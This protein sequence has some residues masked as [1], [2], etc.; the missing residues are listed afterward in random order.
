AAR[1]EPG[2]VG[3]RSAW[4]S[5]TR[6]GPSSPVL[7]RRTDGDRSANRS[8]GRWRRARPSVASEL[9]DAGGRGMPRTALIAGGS[10]GLGRALALGPA[11]EGWDIATD[12]RAGAARQE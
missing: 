4:A 8:A 7:G 2:R 10:R 12:A 9:H 3:Q 5:R 11:R 6:A 1:R